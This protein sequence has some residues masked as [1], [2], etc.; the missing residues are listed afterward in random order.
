M[1]EE[2]HKKAF[3]T[4]ATGY[5]AKHII[6]QLLEAGYDVRA[7]VRQLSR[8]K[9]VKATLANYTS[10][11]INLDEKLEFVTLDL[12]KDE[13]WHDAMQGMDILLHTASPAPATQPKDEN[14]LIKPAV[15][16]TL[17][18]LKAAH[19]VGI[20]RV[21]LTSSVAAIMHHNKLDNRPKLDERDW[22]DINPKHATPYSKSK[23]FAERAAWDFVEQKNV[24]IDLTVINPSMVVGAPLD[25]VIGAS[26][27]IIKRI[28]CRTDPAVPHLGFAYVDVRD[29]AKMHVNAIANDVTFSKRYIAANRF[30]WYCEL[31][32][33]LAAE[34]PE[35]KIITRRAPNWLIKL[36]AI[37]DGDIRSV[38]QDL[39]V[40]RE[41]DNTAAKRDLDMNF[42]D[43][44]TSAIETAHYFIDQKMV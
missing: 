37:F 13:G 2:H 12:Q 19:E 5:I 44:K 41:L 43:V 40:K 30:V 4:G 21:I 23:T 1:S 39:G 35:R 24:N 10:D 33:A 38:S 25:D 32:D 8:G 11:V 36:L 16:G 17:R 14:D 26:T 15:D 20:K 7:S 28:L 42:R 3:V 6:L 31:V 18:A 29:V 9:D 34:F 27:S 22:N